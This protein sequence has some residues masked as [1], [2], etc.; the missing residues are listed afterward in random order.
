MSRFYG[1]VRGA[2]KT[3][4]SRRGHTST[5]VTTYAASWQGAVCCEVYDE[6]GKDHVRVSLVP[7]RGKGVTRELYNG[8]IGKVAFVASMKPITPGAI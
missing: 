8:P 4:A 1:T 6:N 5:G 2:A 3:E 7:W